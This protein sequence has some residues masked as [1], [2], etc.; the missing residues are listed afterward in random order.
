[1]GDIP[2]VVIASDK[3]LREQGF[4]H[5]FS[6][7]FL[8]SHEREWPV[9]QKD[10]VNVSNRSEFWMAKGSGHSIPVEQPE[11]IIKAIL[12]LAHE[13]RSANKRSHSD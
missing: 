10:M 9:L 2:T 13:A 3:T 11:I 7:E 5:L 4:G 8:D 6:E 1:M 12:K